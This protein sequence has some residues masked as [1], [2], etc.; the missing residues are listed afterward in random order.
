MLIGVRHGG[1]LR[2]IV[3][4]TGPGIDPAEQVRIFEEFYQIKNPER[5]R[6]KGLGLGLAIVR[7]I[8]ALIDAP[9][10]LT[11]R[12][13]VGSCFALP[14]I[15]ATEQPLLAEPGIVEATRASGLILVIDDE[16]S[17]QQAM[18]SLLTSWGYRVVVAGSLAEMRARLAG[19]GERPKLLICDRR[20]RDGIDGIDGIDVIAK[21]REE[22][23]ADLPAMLIT[24]DTAPD[25]LGSAPASGFVLLHKPVQSGRLRAAIAN[26]TRV[27]EQDARDSAQS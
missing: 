21:V 7:R 12:V 24:G 14:L 19:T 17:I 11:S 9:L 20:L 6:A 27:A 5:D 4:D 22:F 8:T 10:A 23:G 2:L 16:A 3:C 13:G 26:L 1:G 18:T 25:R 15:A